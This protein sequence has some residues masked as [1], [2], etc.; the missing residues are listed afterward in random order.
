MKYLYLTLLIFLS[1]FSFSQNKRVIDS[2]STLINGKLGV[3][4]YGPLYELAFEFI[5]NNN[6]KALEVITEA[7]SLAVISKD[8]LKIVKCGRVKA[9]LLNRMRRLDLA[10]LEGHKVL[11][12]AKEKNYTNETKYLLNTLALAYTFQAQYDKALEYNFESL[13]ARQKMGDKNEISAAMLNIGFV[14][15]KLKDYK[16]ALTY[17][18]Q[19][20]QLKSEIPDASK[21]EVLLVNSPYAILI[22]L[23]FRKQRCMLKKD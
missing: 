8:T 1:H 13:A 19:S 12:I 3:E 6:G 9:Q 10:I 20:L 21:V 14:Y 17:N 18:F 11:N 15:Y 4:R 7:Q 22:L 5:D 16:K 2:L 23:T